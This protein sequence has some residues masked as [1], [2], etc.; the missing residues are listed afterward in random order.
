MHAAYI[1]PGDVAQV[2]PHP[3]ARSLR[4]ARGRGAGE[5]PGCHAP[6]SRWL[7]KSHRTLQD[8]LC[9]CLVFMEHI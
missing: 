8:E 5:A 1:L 6:L 7:S 2:R 4:P 9:S 3:H